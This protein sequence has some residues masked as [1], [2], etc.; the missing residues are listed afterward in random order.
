M[1]VCQ[2]NFHHAQKLQKRAYNKGVKP[3]SY[4]L[5]DKV[6]LSSKYLKTK[7]NC[8]LEAKFFGSFQ[9]LNSIS[10]Q[11]YKLKLPKK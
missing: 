1:T 4:P 11:V 8:K 5:S 3:R 2:Q 10:K 9:M 7:R 6:W